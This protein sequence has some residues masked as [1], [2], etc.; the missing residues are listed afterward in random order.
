MSQFRQFSERCK[1]RHDFGDQIQVR[2][3]HPG[4]EHYDTWV[5]GSEVLQ[6][7]NSLESEEQ[8]RGLSRLTLEDLKI[9]YQSLPDAAR[10]TVRGSLRDELA[11]RLEKNIGGSVIGDSLSK[12]VRGRSTLS[13]TTQ[14][15]KERWTALIRYEPFHQIVLNLAWIQLE[16]SFPEANIDPRPGDWL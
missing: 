1:M 14:S 16:G 12:A 9:V 8:L 6:R 4:G 3:Q 13:D 7:L 2:Y 11:D 15:E 10:E 5:S